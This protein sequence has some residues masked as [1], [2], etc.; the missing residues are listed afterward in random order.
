VYRGTTSNGESRYMDT[1]TTSITYTGSGE[2]AQTPRATGSK[3]TVKN[4]LELKNARRVTIDGNLFENNWAAAQQGHAI[5]LSP[6]QYQGR[7]PWTIVRDIT[8]TNNILRHA[9]GA[10]AIAGHDS[11][12][13]Q[14][15]TVNVIVRNNLFEDLSPFW[16]NTG[17]GIQITDGP[18]NI[19]IDH[20]TWEHDGTLLEIDGPAV[21]GFVMTN[22]I[23]RHNKY[24]IKGRGYSSGLATL[25]KFMPGY[26]FKANV[27]AGA[28]PALY[29][30]GNY[31]PATS[32]FLTQFVSAATG[33]FRLASTSPYNDKATNGT[34]IGAIFTALETARLA[35]S[36]TGGTSA[37]A[38]RTA[39][40]PA[41]DRLAVA[42]YRR[43]RPARVGD[44]KR[45]R[46]Y[47]QRSGRRRL[48]SGR[49]LPLRLPDTHR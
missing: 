46:D 15:Q 25:N 39:A 47:R 32:L 4:L 28:D 35:K 45:G 36:G 19:V 49:R 40:R 10:L 44:G 11:D 1:S 29:P 43:G 23:A 13:P 5:L 6:N 48:G 14:G 3:W 38:G 42:R 21:P 17:R 31:Y 9:A 22:N 7:A 33:D 8:F 41:A 20:N 37:P 34:D 18:A 12:D 2:L 24:G 26:S 27:L 16:G 30:T